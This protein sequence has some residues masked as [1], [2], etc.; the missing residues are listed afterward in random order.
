VGT[1]WL[2][3]PCV[4]HWGMTFLTN[5]AP[6]PGTAMSRVGAGQSTAIC[7]HPSIHAMGLLIMPSTASQRIAISIHGPQ[8]ALSP[9]RQ[10]I[11]LRLVALHPTGIVYHNVRSVCDKGA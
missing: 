1:H 7:R 9:L 10:K 6:Q 5:I 2:T 11:P 3:G 4:W 8:C